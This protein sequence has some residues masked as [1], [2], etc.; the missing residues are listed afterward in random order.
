MG[1]WT[2]Y[3]YR[4]ISDGNTTKTWW[5]W[6]LPPL[7]SPLNSGETTSFT[8]LVGIWFHSPSPFSQIDLFSSAEYFWINKKALIDAKIVNRYSINND[9]PQGSKA[10]SP[11]ETN[12]FGESR[13]TEVVDFNFEW[14]ITHSL[15]WQKMCKDGGRHANKIMSNET[16]K[17]ESVK[18]SAKQ[19]KKWCPKKLARVPFEGFFVEGKLIQQ[20]PPETLTTDFLLSLKFTKC[21]S[22]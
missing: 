3:V 7:I 22:F 1:Q 13:E 12:R 5:I 11:N 16:R 10:G 20:L 21:V 19:I 15:R 14:R 8:V 4:V 9:E 2:A 17:S 6:Y 18:H